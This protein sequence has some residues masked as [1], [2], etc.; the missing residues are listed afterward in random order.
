MFTAFLD[1]NDAHVVA[2]AWHARAD[3]L[4]TANL[5]DFP[6]E[7]LDP[8]GLHAVTPDCFLLDMLDLAPDTVP[9]LIEEQAAAAAR[10]SMSVED[11]LI[12]L[13]LADAPQFAAAVRNALADK[14]A[15]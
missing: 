5:R 14:S 11:V 4:V 1:A 2:A 9:A 3:A 10:P 13:G 8:L 7:V 15:A 6:A 12:S